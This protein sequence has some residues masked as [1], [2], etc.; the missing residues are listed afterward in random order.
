MLDPA[1]LAQLD[2]DGL[3]V[4]PAVLDAAEVG[5][6]RGELAAAIDED[7]V[8]CPDVF[9]RGMVHNCMAR[10]ERMAALLDHPLLNAWLKAL[11]GDSCI[12][13]AYQSSSVMPGAGNYGSRIHV[14]SPRFIP[15]YATNVGVIFPLDDFTEQNGATWYL[16]GSHLRAE[17]PDETTFRAQASRALCAAGD[18][19]VFNARLAHAAGENRSAHA[20]HAL[21]INACRSYM[22]QRF[23]FPRLLPQALIERLGTDGRRLI[24]MNVRMP[25]SLAEFYLP[26][27]QRLY[28]PGQG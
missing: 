27:D 18:M 14:D 2:Q 1:L 16:R 3:V 17:L 20:R 11:L 25:T 7:L 10:G 23:D 12:L 28:K 8:R 21:T 22:R 9:D 5:T 24:G 4:V 13:Y 26:E 15:G 19:V 6:L